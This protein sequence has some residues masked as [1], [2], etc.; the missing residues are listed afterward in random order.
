MKRLGNMNKIYIIYDEKQNYAAEI[1]RKACMRSFTKGQLEFLTY[2]QATGI[3]EFSILLEP[4]EAWLRSYLP[5]FRGKCLVLG[6]TTELLADYLG[7]VCLKEEIAEN[8]LQQGNFV[9][10]NLFIQYE[11]SQQTDSLVKNWSLKKRY[12]SRCDHLDGWN[13]QGYGAITLTMGTPF[14]LACHTGQ[15]DGNSL[16]KIFSMQGEFVTE[17]AC[18]KNK[19]ASSV[20]WFNRAVGPVDS[21]EWS[22]VENFFAN[23]RSEELP[24]L[25]YLSELP[26]GYTGAMT[27]RLDCDQAIA[28]ARALFEL[29]LDE[30]I[31]MTLAITTGND[32]STADKEFVRDVLR[33]GG[34]VLSHSQHHFPNWGGCYSGAYLEA[35]GSRFW[36]EKNIDKKFS[37]YA[38]SPFHQNPDYAVK[39][40]YDAKYKGFVGG[41]SS[42]D[43]QY[44]MGRG[45]QVP[46][47]KE[48]MV[49]LSQQCMLHG[50]CFHQYGYSIKPYEDCF[51]QYYKANG[52]FG[53][54]DHPFSAADQ[55]GW[56]SETERIG[57]HQDLIHHIK[58]NES[59]WYCNLQEAMEFILAKSRV[60]ISL[61]EKKGLKASTSDTSKKHFKVVYRNEV[62]TI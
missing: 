47:M 17:Y 11:R 15:S 45:G 42:N 62:M 20:L 4:E 19:A 8:V 25:P 14:A 31:P 41:L 2:K 57:V 46:F 39:A 40:L 48:E 16:A 55:Y 18:L 33:H 54:L 44:V 58:K 10:S 52:I 12:L 35:L 9:S 56:N 43:P 50:D 6:K 29:Y 37:G 49:S 13:N 59:I 53:Y 51:D 36:L 1:V 30:E 38:V 24:C 21:L 60:N 5:Q 22:I 3:P 61:D 23:Y 26:A 32:I 34:S 28:S 7:F 27:M